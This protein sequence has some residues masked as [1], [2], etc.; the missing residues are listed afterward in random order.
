MQINRHALYFAPASGAFACAAAAWLGWDAVLGAE[1][2]Q[3]A[4]VGLEEATRAPRK[5]GF[6][7]TFKAPFRLATG[8]CAA[9]LADTGAQVAGRLA[10]VSLEAVSVARMGGFLALRPE[11]DERA[12][13]AL[14]RE[15]VAQF[16]PF[17]APLTP[18]EIEKRRPETLTPRQRALLLEVGYPYV[19][20]EF[21]FHMTLTGALP[22]ETLARLQPLAE[23]YFA[24]HLA[25]PFRVDQLC[26][27]GE[28]AAGRF[29]LLAQYPLRG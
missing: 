5:Y 27:F 23:A 13:Q 11:G 28:D 4:I 3:P 20:E 16:E 6:H 8:V 18:Q 14:C 2:A 22:P 17:R 21:R 10:P 29:H 9:D 24:P 25:R 1:V 15:I 19:F 26:H 12:L 7:A